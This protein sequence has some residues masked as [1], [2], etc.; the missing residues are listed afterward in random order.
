[1]RS[2]VEEIAHPGRLLNVIP[3]NELGD[4]LRRA[5]FLPLGR[6]CG[7]QPRH[8]LGKGSDDSRP[9]RV[10]HATEQPLPTPAHQHDIIVLRKLVQDHLESH[11]APASLRIKPLNPRRPVLHKASEAIFRQPVALRSAEEFLVIDIGVTEAGRHGQADLGSAAAHFLGD[12]QNR[13]GLILKAHDAE[14]DRDQDRALGDPKLCTSRPTCRTKSSTSTPTRPSSWWCAATT[15]RIV[16][17]LDDVV[18]VEEPE[19]VF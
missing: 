3:A 14:D 6:Q 11:D 1:L 16:V 7:G 8:A 15:E 9:K 12:R 17:K 10:E 13:H 19:P 2:T 18:P 4:D 5:A